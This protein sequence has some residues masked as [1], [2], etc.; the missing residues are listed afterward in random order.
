MTVKLPDNPR[1]ADYEDLVASCFLGLGYFIETNLVLRDD[2]TDVLELDVVA[3]SAAEPLVCSILVEA[4]SGS[5][6]GFSDVFKMFGWMTYLGINLGMLV[7]KKEI[8]KSKQEALE[9][10]ASKTGVEVLCFDPDVMGLSS[11]PDAPINMPD[12]FR[13]HLITGTWWGRIGQRVCM[14]SFYSLVKSLGSPGATA[15]RRYKESVDNSFFAKRPLGRARRLYKAYAEAPKMSGQLVDELGAGDSERTKAV[16]DEARGSSERRGVQYCMVLEG[17]ARLGILKNALLHILHSESVEDLSE[18]ERLKVLASTFPQSLQQGLIWLSKHPRRT[19]IPYLMQ[20]FIE[21]FGGF[22]LRSEPKE[23]ELLSVATE[24]PQ[25]EVE[26]CLG[27]FDQLFPV[28]NSWFFEK[29]GLRQMKAI[30][31]VYRGT[32]AWLRQSVYGIKDYEDIFGDMGWLLTKW[33]NALYET[34]KP[35]LGLPATTK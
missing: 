21:V 29:D 23:L 6:P 7:R 24:I 17:R 14:K 32:G 3:T 33:H 13:T 2:T 16:W 8:D 26:E 30:P 28:P 9:R 25:G 34:L 11:L 1:E 15:A 19:R 10:V 18:K 5:A 31:A 12:D 4:K 35:E 22:Y 27:A 20:V